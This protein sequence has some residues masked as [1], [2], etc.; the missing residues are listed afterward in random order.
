MN[1]CV[2]TPYRFAGLSALAAVIV[3]CHGTLID[4]TDRDVYDLLSQRQQAALGETS[5]VDIGNERGNVSG[6]SEMY[7]FTPHVITPEIPDEFRSSRETAVSEAANSE[8]EGDVGDRPFAPEAVLSPSIFADADLRDVR[9]F[10]LHDALMYATQHARALQDAKEE[11]YLAALDLT[12]ERHLWTPQFV[13]SMKAQGDFA[14]AGGLHDYDRALTA[15]S[16]FSVSQR[17]PYGGEISAQI[18]SALVRD[19]EDH[20]T[21]GESGDLILKADIPLLRGAGRSAYETRYSAERELIYAVRLYERFR[22]SFLVDVAGRLFTLQQ[23]KAAIDNTYTAY[24]SRIRDWE[25]ADFINRVGQS[26]DVFEAPRAKASLRQAEAALV[27]TK[28]R[29]ATAL[30]RFKIFIGMPVSELLD[31][32]D[33][34][35]DEASRRLDDLLPVV[36][37]STAVETALRSRLD[38]LNSVDL[39]DDSRRGVLVA[40]NRI[41]PDLDVTAGFNFDSDPERLNS[42]SY[43]PERASW[44]GG[45][46]LS[47]DDR[48]SERNAYR[49]ALI[50]LRRAQRNHQELID[51][52]RADVRR[53]LRRITEKDNL[54]RIQSLNVEENELRLEAARA[55][56]DLGKR[57]NQDVVDAENDLLAARN[58]YATAV[59]EYRNA[60]LQFRL[61]T[62]TLRVTADGRWDESGAGAL[63]GQ[64]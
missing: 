52:V 28:E 5:N 63:S 49:A 36:Q 55:Q 4:R 40:R 27:S 54:R 31:V 11:L 12:L 41:L 44:H 38:L 23:S 14:D 33:Q 10:S 7:S 24:R 53:A 34:H 64:E 46:E 62:G 48:K 61:D 51:N 1:T 56:F 17:L 42:A 59:A 32:V 22:R 16:D 18:V 30:D 43:N 8:E 25:K 20:V 9:V 47:L 39:L 45:L 21:S 29:Y 60:I 58:E 57:T 50:G 6:A 15:T 13:A 2:G 37:V 3:G 19:L 26:R 35:A